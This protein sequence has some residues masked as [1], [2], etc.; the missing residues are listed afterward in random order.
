MYKIRIHI[1]IE[2]D[3]MDRDVYTDIILPFVP[4]IGNI[5]H[6]SESQIAELEGR[7]KSSL[8]IA[9][10]YAPRWFHG[11]SYLC[12]NPTEE[13]LEDLNF[14]DAIT[15]QQLLFKGDSNIIE[16]ELG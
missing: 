10:R 2:N 7:A 1:E 11:H 8:D 6:L 4:Q 14:E 16:I 15:V 12:E 3:F 13:N 5:V 9:R